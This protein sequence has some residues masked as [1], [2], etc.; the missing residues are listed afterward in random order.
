MKKILI[1][2]FSILLFFGCD[3][4]TP[5]APEVQEIDLSSIRVGQKSKYA[6][7]VTTCNEISNGLIL[8]SNIPYLTLGL[9]VI[10]EG[11][12]LYLKEN[13]DVEHLIEIRPRGGYIEADGMET[14][15]SRL[16]YSHSVDPL[17]IDSTQVDVKPMTMNNCGLSF[18]GESGTLGFIDLFSLAG[19]EYEN[20]LVKVGGGNNSNHYIIYDEHQIYLTLFYRISNEEVIIHKLIE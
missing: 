11:E 13:T 7:Y 9:E 12:L 10:Q 3:I 19:I 14:G 17:W 20:K 5:P 8:D 4:N 1:F 2:T 6:R 15:F 18:N 16:F